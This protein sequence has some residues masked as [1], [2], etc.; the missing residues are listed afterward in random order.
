MKQLFFIVPVYKV[1]AYLPRC[2][3][4]VLGQT[5]G[6]CQTVLVDDGSPDGSPSICDEYAKKYPNVSVIHKENGGL[7][8]ARNAGIEFA[9]ARSGDGDYLTFLDS[10]DFVS[11]T[12][13]EKMVGLCEENA[14]AVAQCEYEKG[15]AA[16]F[17]GAE[18]A[19]ETAVFDASEALLGYRLKSMSCAKV[20]RADCLRDLRFKTGVIN[21]D[22]FFTYRAVYAGGRTAFTG[23]KLYYYYQHDESIM[24]DVAKH[25]KNNPHRFDFMEAYRERIAFF[26]AENAPEQVQRTQEKICSDCFLRYNEQMLLPYDR[27]DDECNNGTYMRMYRDNFRRMI[28]R[29][30]MPFKRRI[31]YNLFYILPRAFVLLGRFLQYRD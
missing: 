28:R 15:S 22:E 21:E 6:G 23:E 31:I 16:N 2:M 14:C 17:R 4:S 18:K 8:D 13:A 29:K 20:Y 9:L 3:E 5:Y 27:R 19:P 12:F 25:L 26:E 24:S 30:G 10:D 11:A 7:A 1:E